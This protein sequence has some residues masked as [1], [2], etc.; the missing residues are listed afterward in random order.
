MAALRINLDVASWPVRGIRGAR[1]PR[2]SCVNIDS[3][4]MMLG[5][6]RHSG[7]YGALIAGGI[8]ELSGK[9]DLEVGRGVQHSRRRKKRWS[10]IPGKGLG[11]LRRPIGELPL[12]L[13]LA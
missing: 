3:F 5:W 6:S 13:G 7:K 9:S 12:L 1:F 4:D 2:R 8:R 10:G 11:D